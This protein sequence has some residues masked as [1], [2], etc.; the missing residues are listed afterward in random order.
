MQPHDDAKVPYDK[1]LR[2]RANESTELE[3]LMTKYAWV[4]HCCFYW[5]VSEQ[6]RCKP[7][8]LLKTRVA[9]LS[10][11]LLLKFDAQSMVPC[12]ICGSHEGIKVRCPGDPQELMS[13]LTQRVS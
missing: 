2:H 7:A 10:L 9:K 6:D 12:E 3:V 8:D 13:S 1:R 11:D 5:L 4:H